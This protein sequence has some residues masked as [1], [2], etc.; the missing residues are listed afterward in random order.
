MKELLNYKTITQITES[1][2]HARNAGEYITYPLSKKTLEEAYNVF[3]EEFEF[4]NRMLDELCLEQ[5]A[6]EEERATLSSRLER[7][8]QRKSETA[9]D[10]LVRRGLGTLNWEIEVV[11]R[12]LT[13]LAHKSSGV[14]KVQNKVVEKTVKYIKLRKEAEA[15]YNKLYR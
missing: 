15:V 7:L 11:E 12:A 14:S 13:E 10:P 3:R 1:C 4:Y 9:D 2:I 8:E 6:F 5:K